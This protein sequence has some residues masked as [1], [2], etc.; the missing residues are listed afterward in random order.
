MFRTLHSVKRVPS[1]VW[2]YTTTGRPTCPV[3]NSGK[4][5]IFRQFVTLCVQLH[6]MDCCIYVVRYIKP[7]MG[8][9]ILVNAGVAFSSTFVFKRLAN[10][11]KESTL[12]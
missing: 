7:S 10:K 2:R 8:D 9:D 11:Q 6:S 12:E 1:G 5:A 4:L 3:E